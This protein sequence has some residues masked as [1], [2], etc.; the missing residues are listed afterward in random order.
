MQSV[1]SGIWTRVTESISYDD[2]HY[3]T[4]K[5][6]QGLED[7]TKAK[8]H[9]DSLRTTPQKVPN[10]QTPNYDGTFFF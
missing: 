7:D 10:W 4:G 2:N 5:E 6:L 1:S 9:L 8:I 3:T